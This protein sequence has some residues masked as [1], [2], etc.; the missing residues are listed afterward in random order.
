M[1]SVRGSILF[2]AAAAAAFSG[3][4]TGQTLATFETFKGANPSTCSAPPPASSFAASDGT[5]NVY[6]LLNSV[7]PGDVTKV[8]W[9]NPVGANAWYTMW[10]PTPNDGYTSRCYWLNFD[11]A[12]YI[13]PSWGLWSA[14]ITVNDRNVGS[15]ISFQVNSGAQPPAATPEYEG[16]FDGVDCSHIFGWARNKKD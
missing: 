7:H 15:P 16:S 4:A 11:I 13:A 3:I 10:D 1:R 2:V 12:K 14:Q 9:L 5:V 6:F 8:L